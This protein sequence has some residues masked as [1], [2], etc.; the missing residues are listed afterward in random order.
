VVDLEQS[1]RNAE[2]SLFGL[3][4]SDIV[5]EGAPDLFDITVTVAVVHVE[6]NANFL[7]WVKELFV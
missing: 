2:Q 6:L 1:I 3:P 7:V 4:N 5:F